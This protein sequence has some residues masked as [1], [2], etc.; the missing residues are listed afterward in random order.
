M[1]DARLAH[2]EKQ[3]TSGAREGVEKA[4]PAGNSRLLSTAEGASSV[5]QPSTN[6]PQLSEKGHLT[7]LIF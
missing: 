7:G 3:S 1:R 2:S 6:N 4:P 5:P